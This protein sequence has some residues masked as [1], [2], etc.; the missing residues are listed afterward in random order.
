[1]AGRVVVAALAGATVLALTGCAGPVE[2][3]AWPEG[4]GPAAPAAA[5]Q[6]RTPAAEP[7]S[8]PAPPT[9]FTVPGPL[10]SD[11][12]PPE[13]P[14]AGPPGEAPATRTVPPV[15]VGPTTGAT[16]GRTRPPAPRADRSRA[17]RTATPAVPRAGAPATRATAPAA[18]APLTADVLRDECLV[19]AQQ[20]A[21]LLG[22]APAAPAANAEVARSDGSRARSCFA[23]GGSATVSVN[24]YATNLTDPAGYVRAAAGARP[25]TGTGDGTAAALIETVGGPTLQ[26]GTGRHLVTI[27]VA[28][29]APDDAAWQ[30]AARAAVAALALR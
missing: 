12:V 20:L 1:M 26:L 30:R 7:P 13:L 9:S 5:G 10:T 29:A 25:L 21:G 17:P 6:D 2:G 16:D 19:P 11:P 28:G 3:R 22:T 8:E 15:P 24:V 14:T 18:P 23:V 4:Q 27:A